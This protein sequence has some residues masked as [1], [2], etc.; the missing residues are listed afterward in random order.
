[1]AATANAVVLWTI[2]T[3]CRRARM[4]ATR[5]RTAFSPLPA[6]EILDL[7]NIGRRTCRQWET[8]VTD[9]CASFYAMQNSIIRPTSNRENSR[10]K[11]E[12]M[13]KSG[14]RLSGQFT[15]LNDHI[16][17]CKSNDCAFSRLG[18]TG[19]HGPCT[20]FS[21]RCRFRACARSKAESIRRVRRSCGNPCACARA[22]C[23]R[24]NAL[25]GKGHV[26]IQ[27]PDSARL[28]CQLIE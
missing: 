27:F 14:D 15:A 1:M 26:R 16:P 6:C 17:R 12:N 10:Q 25:R 5:K 11:N 3:C 20:S 13:P 19:P 22:R 18:P 2:V 28:T 4:S 23:S 8:D 7:G 9:F 24:R 21:S